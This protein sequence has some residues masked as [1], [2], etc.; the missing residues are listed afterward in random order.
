MINIFYFENFKLKCRLKLFYIYFFYIFFM[1]HISI[2]VDK[3]F[4]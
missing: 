4:L 2:N 1:R 3:I